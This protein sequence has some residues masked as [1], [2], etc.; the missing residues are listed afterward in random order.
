MEDPIDLSLMEHIQ[1]LAKSDITKEDLTDS[2]A[3]FH[4]KYLVHFYICI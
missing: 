2:V 3:L 1:I 4:G